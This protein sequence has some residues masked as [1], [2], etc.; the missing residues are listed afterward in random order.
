M[1]Q[2]RLSHQTTRSLCSCLLTLATHVVALVGYVLYVRRPVSLFHPMRCV[3]Q[4][5][6]LQLAHG[7]LHESGL[8]LL[9]VCC[10]PGFGSQYAHS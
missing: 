2:Q 1:H 6:D 8:G 5:V 3:G 10:L 7:T 9:T 4:I